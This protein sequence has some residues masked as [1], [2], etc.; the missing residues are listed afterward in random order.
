MRTVGMDERW[1]VECAIP[2]AG[3]HRNK[4]LTANNCRCDGI[5]GLGCNGEPT[6]VGRGTRSLPCIATWP[7]WVVQRAVTYRNAL[8][9][10]TAGS[11]G[12]IAPVSYDDHESETN[13]HRK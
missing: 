5:S 6:R 11:T 9:R 4:V 2:E 3:F 7:L 10:T 13:N 8:S 12:D 1:R